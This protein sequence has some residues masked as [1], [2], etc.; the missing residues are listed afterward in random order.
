M[1]I[2]VREMEEKDLDRIVEIEDKCFAV[3]WPRKSFE[4]EVNSNLLS[5]YIV[6]E[7][8]GIILGYM[9]IWL[10]YDEAHVVSIG[11]DPEFRRNGIGK[12]LMGVGISE[13]IRAGMNNM[14]LEVRK[15]NIAAKRL[16]EEFGFAPV[17]IRPKYYQ[18]N[19][20]D[21]VI[22]WKYFKDV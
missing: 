19:N 2:T 6:A 8:E 10:M 9:G 15:S 17:G 11:V 1:D 14:T 12:I 13:V 3:P 5:R 22:M 16:Y 4:F 7:R 18:D 21:A 20:E